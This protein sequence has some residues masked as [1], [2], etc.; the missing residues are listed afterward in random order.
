LP[1]WRTRRKGL[2]WTLRGA[3][4]C[5]AVVATRAARARTADFMVESSAKMKLRGKALWRGVDV[6]W[7]MSCEASWQLYHSSAKH[8]FGRCDND[9]V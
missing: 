9:G 5:A 2:D 8:A 7:L 3:R 1:E 4:D 6:W